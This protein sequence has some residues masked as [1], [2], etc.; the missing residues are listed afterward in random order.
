MTIGANIGA[1]GARIQTAERSSQ[2]AQALWVRQST[3]GAQIVTVGAHIRTAGVQSTIAEVLWLHRL[4]CQSGLPKRVVALP[5]RVIRMPE[6][7]GSDQ[8]LP[9]RTLGLL[10]R[11]FTVGNRR[12]KAV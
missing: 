1:A 12:E 8:V 2:Y 5:K 11:V 6:H 4:H 3:I 10:E 7:Y 9:E